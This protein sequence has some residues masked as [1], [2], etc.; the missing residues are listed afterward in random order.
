MPSG[1]RYSNPPI[2]IGPCKTQ[3]LLAFF[4]TWITWKTRVKD[5]C[6]TRT[7]AQAGSCFYTCS[8]H[9][10]FPWPK[11]RFYSCCFYTK[12]R[13]KLEQ[14]TRVKHKLLHKRGSFFC[15][16]SWHVHFPWPKHRFYSFFFHQNNV[17]NSCKTQTLHKRI[18]CSWH[19]YFPLSKLQKSTCFHT[20]VI[21]MLQVNENT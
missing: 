9:V 21:L 20:L 16:C 2:N 14:K 7:F 4:Y 15:T 6:K 3:V 5:S 8:W 13:E 12:L 1:Y 17:K 18:S 10:N 11:H 19:V